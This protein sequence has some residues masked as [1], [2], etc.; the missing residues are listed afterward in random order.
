M[1]KRTVEVVA[2]ADFES[3]L[4]TRTSEHLEEYRALA[5]RAALPDGGALTA[6]EMERA[7]ELLDALHLPLTTF[8]RDVDGIHHRLKLVLKLEPLVANATSDQM[9]ARELADEIAGLTKLISEKRFLLHRHDTALPAK[10][11]A[12]EQSVREIDADRFH[13]FATLEAATAKRVAVIHPT[14]HEGARA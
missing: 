4:R 5:F 1:A 9:K 6:G 3:A 13:L 14:L 2:P 10:T 12:L 8:Q 11:A 7:A